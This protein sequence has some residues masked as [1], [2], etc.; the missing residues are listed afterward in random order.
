MG[1][2]TTVAAS[3]IGTVAEHGS[4]ARLCLQEDITA[5]YLHRSFI[6]GYARSVK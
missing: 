4:T 1:M 5:I 3:I 6:Q 2:A